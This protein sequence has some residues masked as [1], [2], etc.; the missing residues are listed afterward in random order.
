MNDHDQ[1]VHELAAAYAV[2]AVDDL[3]RARF[4]AHLPGCFRCTDLVAE[5]REAAADL[6]SG[7]EV[8]PPAHLR[9]RVLAAV[10]ADTPGATEPRPAAA[11]GDRRPTTRGRARP[12]RSA[13][14]WIAAAAA[15]A[16]LAG[17]W[18]VVQLRDGD[19][20]QQILA[21]EDAREFSASTDVGTVDV[22][23]SITRDAAVLRLPDEVGPPP[24]GRAYQAWFVSAD[25][26]ARSA[27]LIGEDQLDDGGVVLQGS[28]EGAAAVG[29]T[30]EPAGGS[31]QPTTEPFAVI[32]LG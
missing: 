16:L 25:G 20:A 22:V 13:P 30:L 6:S 7:L 1:Q 24:E 15:A 8:A 28:P 4:E 32:P 10:Q 5:L 27:G 12:R 18:G 9:Q 23:L 14:R 29:V 3:E 11:P 26:S 31:P 2:D 17:T 19:P 21:A